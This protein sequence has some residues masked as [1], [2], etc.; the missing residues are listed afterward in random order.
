MKILIIEKAGCTSRFD[1]FLGMLSKKLSYA[2]C[3]KLYTY[4]ELDDVYYCNRLKILNPKVWGYS[5]VIYKLR[6]DCKKE[7]VRILF[8]KIKNNNL[9]ILHAFIK[10]TRK[11]PNKEAKIAIHNFNQLGGGENLRP[12]N[13]NKYLLTYGDVKR[14]SI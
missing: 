8:V 13:L 14:V 10:K 11:T 6:V 9:V 3:K 4:S 12:L 1:C 7:S 2:I 5:G